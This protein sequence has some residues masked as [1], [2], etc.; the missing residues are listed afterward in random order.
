LHPAKV[1]NVCGR[2]L[3][4]QAIPA[5]QSVFAQPA[6]KIL[7]VR[8]IGVVIAPGREEFEPNRVKF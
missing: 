5:G 2:R 4:K 7:N 6:L 1:V 3:V 8:A